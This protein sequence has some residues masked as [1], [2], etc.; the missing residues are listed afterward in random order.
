VYRC[1][2]PFLR[3]QLDLGL[4]KED[5]VEMYYNAAIGKWL[6]AYAQPGAHT[7]RARAAQGVNMSHLALAKDRSESAV[8][9]FLPAT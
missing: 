4:S 1:Y 7:R 6:T 9:D 8:V 2:V 5:A 3:P